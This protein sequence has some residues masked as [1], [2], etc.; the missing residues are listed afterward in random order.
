MTVDPGRRLPPPPGLVEAFRAYEQALMTNDLAELDRLFAP[1]PTTMRGDA[2][3]L[4][5]GHHM[6]SAFRGGR[7]GAPARRIVQTHVQTIDDDHALVVAVTELERGGRGQQTQLWARFPDG[8]AVTAAHVSVPPPALDT[9]VWR[10]VGDPLVPA[11]GSG[12]LDGESVAVKDLYAVAGQ[13]V[14]A[15]NP[16]WLEQ[17]PA[18]TQHA[19]AVASLLAAGASIRGIART[20]EFAYSLAGANAHTGSPPNP[21]APYRLSGGST[22]GSASAVSLGQATIGLGTD[23]GGSIRVPAAYQGLFGIRTT[24]GAIPRDGLLALAPGFD[25]VGWLT[26]TASLLRTVGDVLLPPRVASSGTRLVGVPALTALAESDVVAAVAGIPVDATDD[27]PLPDLQ[28]WRAAFQTWQAWEAWQ[29]R[30]SWLTGRLDTLG[31][32]VRSRFEHAA[33]I[34]HDQADAARRTVDRAARAI[35]DLVGDDVLVIPSASSVAPRVGVDLGP[36]RT[37]TMT[38]TSI[39][40]LAGLPAVSLPVTTSGGLPAGACLVAAPGRDR[41]LLDLAVQLSGT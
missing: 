10:L 38:L 17:A 36:V 5:V 6:I 37:A 23:T 22:S 33:S 13:R 4:L 32:D 25:T 29:V 28:A 20:D 3:G 8:W 21:R 41:D 26:R 31:D 24:H 9:R 7:G 12:A 1:G 11:T 27:R 18:E 16:A 30:G 19:A 35:R 2:Q 40:G 39:A 34:G 15:G 14:G